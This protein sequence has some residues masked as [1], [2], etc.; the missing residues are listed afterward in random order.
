MLDMV[1]AMLCFVTVAVSFVYGT[2]VCW[3]C[4][5][6]CS[7][8]VEP[9][10]KKQILKGRMPAGLAIYAF[11][12]FVLFSFILDGTIAVTVSSLTS[13]LLLSHF[14]VSMAMPAFKSPPS[15]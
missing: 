10:E 2:R 12:F 14:V 5:K 13:A 11:G 9:V 1:S 3:V 6:D 4:G 7:F 8:K 15:P